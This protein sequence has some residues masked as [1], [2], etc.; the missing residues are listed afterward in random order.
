MDEQV[1]A[2]TRWWSWRRQRLDRSCRGI[3]DCLRSV[4]GI[5]GVHPSAPLSLLARVPR[6]M[7]G[8]YEGA[9]EGRVA[10]RLPA[11]RRQPHILHGETAHLVYHACR[12]G[13]PR[14]N[15][16]AD[17]MVRAIRNDVLRAARDPKTADQL[18][19]SV[20]DAPERFVPLLRQMTLDGQL[21]RMRAD[22]VWSNEFRYVATRGWLGHSMP[23]A[24]PDDALIWLAGEYITTYGPAT[25]DD[26]AWWTGL[27]RDL[28]VE[29]FDAHDLADVG[30]GLK[31]SRKDAR[32]LDLARPVAGRVNLLPALDPYTMGYVGDSRRRFA[33]DDRVLTA[34]YDKNENS[35]NVV[36]I[37]GQVGGLWDL[38]HAKSGA[39]EMRIGLFDDPGPKMWAA[40]QSEATLIS[41][42]LDARDFKVVRAKVRLPA[43]KK[44]RA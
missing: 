6:L 9:L 17:P 22:S 38:Q 28:A 1:V 36:L 11:M 7:Q 40:I 10:L 34:M 3:D 30:Y 29:A 8:M 27:D 14:R 42:F 39:V 31:M 12:L 2:L 37:E 33:D 32:S 24:E 41:G 16:R 19:G 44:S 26:F 13:S 35:G 18:R 43:A 21:L 4:V 23:P 15:G 5:P 20:K 25:V